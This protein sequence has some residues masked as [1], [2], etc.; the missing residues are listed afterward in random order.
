M[1]T[2]T[3][4]VLS[5][6]TMFCCICALFIRKTFKNGRVENTFT[7]RVTHSTLLVFYCLNIVFSIII[8]LNL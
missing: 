6:Y 1:K 4:I 8:L 5:M 3:V 7:T 2:L